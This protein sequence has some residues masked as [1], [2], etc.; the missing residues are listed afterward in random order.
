MVFEP[1]IPCGSSMDLT[2]P[3]L[4]SR[5]AFDPGFT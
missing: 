1:Y 5:A 4:L 2:D 3:L